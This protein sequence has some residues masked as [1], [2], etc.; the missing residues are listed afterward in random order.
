MINLNNEKL[1]KKIYSLS[2]FSIIIFFIF[3]FIKS[4][5]ISCGTNMKKIKT[6]GSESNQ[7]VKK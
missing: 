1:S 2:F 5:I 4:K 7:G 6:G 3:I